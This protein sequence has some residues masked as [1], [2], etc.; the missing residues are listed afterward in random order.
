MSVLLSLCR[1]ILQCRFPFSAGVVPDDHSM[2]GNM[3]LELPNHLLRQMVHTFLRAMPRARCGGDVL[4]EIESSPSSAAFTDWEDRSSI[5]A[6]SLTA[7]I[8]LGFHF[9]SSCSSQKLSSMPCAIARFRFVT[10]F[11]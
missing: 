5:R 10:H 9:P 7:L 3:T 4:A 2:F 1:E 11:G 6:F 8:F